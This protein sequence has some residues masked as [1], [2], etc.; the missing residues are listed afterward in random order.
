VVEEQEEEEKIEK[1]IF[2]NHGFVYP[3]AP[4]IWEID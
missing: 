4:R 1:R 2:L 3:T